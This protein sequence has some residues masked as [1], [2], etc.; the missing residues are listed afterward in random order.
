MALFVKGQSG[1]PGGR[2]KRP[3]TIAKRELTK[4]VKELAKAHSSDAVRTL[5]DV[6]NDK[7]APPGARLMAANS[8]LDRGWG[9]P[10]QTI[11][12]NV[13]TSFDGMTDDE[14]REFIAREAST[15]SGSNLAVVVSGEEESG[16]EFS[17]R[18]H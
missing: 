10:Q 11:E 3:E 9:K 17:G 2:P 1:N 18:I 7:K 6:M 15:I 12:A 8:L 16:G 5:I 4:D 13:T 14:L